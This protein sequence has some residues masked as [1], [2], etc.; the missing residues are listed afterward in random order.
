MFNSIIPPGKTVGIVGGGQLGRMMA[1]AAREMGYYIAVL[2]PTEHSPC[3]QIA[4]IEIIGQYDDLDSIKKLAAV[5]DVIT[6][7]FENISVEMVRWLQSNSYVPQGSHVLEITQNRKLEKSLITKLGLHVPPYQ[8]VKAEDELR[9]AI[10]AIGYPCVVKTCMG[11]YDGK[12][13]VVVKDDSDILS[14]SKLLAHSE[15]IVEKWMQLDKEISVIVQRNVNGDTT[16]FPVAENI[17]RH[18]IL[19][20]SIVPARIDDNQRD[21]ALHCAKVIADGLELVGTLTVEMFI[22]ENQDIY[23]NELAPR[24]HNSGH[25]SIEACNLSQFQQHIRAICNWPLSEPVLLKPAV[26]VNLLGEHVEA[27]IS[28]IECFGDIHLHLY[29]KKVAKEKRKMGHITVLADKIED[30]VSKAESL[31]IWNRTEEYTT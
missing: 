24:P 16:C 10:H 28:K 19:H 5:S 22:T 1:I 11:G 7:E 25:F 9:H 26:M 18:H 3:G 20:Q 2:D 31:A 6:Y 29:G 4:D 30:A 23:M 12:G 27:A 14:A 8:I 15:C 17:H 21:Q 13:Q